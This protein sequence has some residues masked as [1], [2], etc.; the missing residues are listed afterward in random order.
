MKYYIPHISLKDLWLGVCWVACLPFHLLFSGIIA[1]RQVGKKSMLKD[2][3]YRLNWLC[4]QIIVEPEQ[5]IRKMPSLL[6]RHYQG[7]WAIYTCAMAVMALANHIRLQPNARERNLKRIEQIIDI[8]LAPEL[9]EYDTKSW[10]E[11]ALASLDG[12][13]SHMTYLSLLAWAITNYKL[14][15]G[16]SRYDDL[17]HRL[18]STLNRRT[19]AS[20]NLNLRSFPTP[21]IFLP[22]MLVT[23]VALKNY[24]DLYGGKYADTVRL[25]VQTAQDKWLHSKTGLLVAMLPDG[26]NRVQRRILGSYTALS[27][28]YLTLI[29]KDFAQDQYTRMVHHLRKDKPLTGIREYQNASPTLRFDVDAGPI[30][31][32]LSPSG[33]VFAV[34][35]AVY[36]NDTDLLRRM[37][38]TADVAGQTV[39]RHSK[40]HYRLG[41]K[42]LV[43][44][45]AMLAMR[46]NYPWQCLR[47]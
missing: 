17:L 13:K 24:A 27:T 7:E 28:Y 6:G 44:E 3:E 46:T 41:E 38:R 31:F 22:D 29:D 8:I 16:L 42:V 9:R 14:S 10:H 19:V 30:A 11:D 21:I 45:A 20:Q 25:W 36:F 43:G 37:M 35:G 47:S 39:Y 15:G 18:C 1:R 40:R 2:V 26:N 34:G 5:L 4:E 12:N 32:G 33:T 23:I